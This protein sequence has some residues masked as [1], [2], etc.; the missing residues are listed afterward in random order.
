MGQIAAQGLEAVVLTIREAEEE[1]GE[2]Q[3]IRTAAGTDV[4]L[5]KITVQLCQSAK[6]V[7]GK[8]TA[9]G[10]KGGGLLLHEGN[11]LR[12]STVK[13]VGVLCP[14]HQVEK[15]LESCKIPLPARSAVRQGL[16]ARF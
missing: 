8:Y 13:H 10:Q 7:L 1:D 6:S 12:A 2:S 3:Q 9:T 4:P 5:D 16:P 15:C 11:G 14:G